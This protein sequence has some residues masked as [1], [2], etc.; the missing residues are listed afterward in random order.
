MNQSD[1]FSGLFEDRPIKT[2][3]VTLALASGTFYLAMFCGIIWFERFGS[4]KKRTI[5]NK[6]GPFLKNFLNPKIG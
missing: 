3:G 2:I 6:L 5:L 1:F 4:D